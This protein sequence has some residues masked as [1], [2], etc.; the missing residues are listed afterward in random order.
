MAG[1]MGNEYVTIESLLVYKTDFKN[2]LIFIKGAVPG[3][4][5]QVVEIKDAFWKKDKQYKNLLYPTFIPEKGKT[6]PDV[7]IFSN[8]IDRNEVFRH[9]NDEVLGVSDEEEEGDEE[10]DD[11][12]VMEVK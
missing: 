7:E 11:E 12:D 3:F 8:S 2:S 5:G 9:A 10:E 1:Q 6:I 4:I